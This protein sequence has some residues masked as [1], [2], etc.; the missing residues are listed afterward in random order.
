[1]GPPMLGNKG[2]EA[3]STSPAGLPPGGVEPSSFCPADRAVGVLA[4]GQWGG[5]QLSQV[6]GTVV[7]LGGP[8]KRSPQH[9]G[10][11]GRNWTVGSVP[12]LPSPR[13][14]PLAHCPLTSSLLLSS[15]AVLPCPTFHLTLSA[16][17]GPRDLG[18]HLTSS[19]S[20]VRC[21]ATLGTSGFCWILPFHFIIR[22]AS[23]LPFKTEMS[24]WFGSHRWALDGIL[25]AHPLR[26]PE[27]TSMCWGYPGLT[28]FHIRQRRTDV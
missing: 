2:E 4:F 27:F 1:M 15:L 6:L 8:P 25:S 7:S 12:V 20:I 18:P 10:Y 16:G 5:L 13:A 26:W 22:P 28:V 21:G 23:Y 19:Y 3:C 14:I 24:A 17:W 11:G 9:S